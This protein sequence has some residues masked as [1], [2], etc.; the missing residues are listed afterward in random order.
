M[1]LMEKTRQQLRELWKTNP[2]VTTRDLIRILDKRL[3]W[4]VGVAIVILV[5]IFACETLLLGLFLAGV[6]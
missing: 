6:W 1:T 3:P 2:K 4:P 5:A